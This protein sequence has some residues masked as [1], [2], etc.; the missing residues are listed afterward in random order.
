MAGNKGPIQLGGG[1]EEEGKEEE[2]ESRGRALAGRLGIRTD[3][4]LESD[5]EPCTPASAPSLLTPNPKL[6]P[7]NQLLGLR[8]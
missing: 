6:P 1:G 4:H 7:P 2:R 8:G 5:A 3:G